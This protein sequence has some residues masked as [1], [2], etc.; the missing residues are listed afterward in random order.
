[1]PADDVDQIP[2]TVPAV[3]ELKNFLINIL[4]YQ[5]Y[6]FQHGFCNDRNHGPHEK[7]YDEIFRNGTHQS[8]IHLLADGFRRAIQNPDQS[9]DWSVEY[10]ARKVIYDY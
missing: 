10:L 1:M 3:R 8:L 7:T 9:T 2:G 4:V 5:T 6:G